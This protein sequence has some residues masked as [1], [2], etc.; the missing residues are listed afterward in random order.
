MYVIG[1]FRTYPSHRKDSFGSASSTSESEE[2]EESNSTLAVGDLPGAGGTSVLIFA[3]GQQALR[4]RGVRC[5][6]TRACVQGKP[7]T[8]VCRLVVGIK[9]RT[10]VSSPRR[11]V[12]QQCAKCFR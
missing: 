7:V 11:T 2:S 1:V 6:F 8:Q 12:A 3:F 10:C 9:T 4:A 5:P